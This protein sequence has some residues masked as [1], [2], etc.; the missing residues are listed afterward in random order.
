LIAG[1]EVRVDEQPDPDQWLSLVDACPWN[2]PDKCN[3]GNDRYVYEFKAGSHKSTLGEAYVL[4][5]WRALADRVRENGR[6]M[7]VTE[8]SRALGC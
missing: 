6:R 1:W 4:G 3:P 7:P 8:L 5:P 2:E